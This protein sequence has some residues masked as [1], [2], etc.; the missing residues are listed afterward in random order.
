MLRR[1]FQTFHEDASSQLLASLSI[2]P[3]SL[4]LSV[5]LSVRF[6]SRLLVG[7]AGLSSLKGSLYTDWKFS[8]LAPE[9]LFR[10]YLAI[11]NSNHFRCPSLLY[12]F[13]G[14][15]SLDMIS[16]GR[17]KKLHLVLHSYQSCTLVL[18]I[19]PEKLPLVFVYP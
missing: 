4:C 8:D 1:A 6:R 12:S 13:L 9:L 7:G 11:K 3:P 19:W 16:M 15:N 14:A 5:C 10:L 17:R 18:S 2:P